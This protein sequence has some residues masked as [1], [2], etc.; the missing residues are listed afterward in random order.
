MSIF[1]DLFLEHSSQ[2]L[3]SHVHQWL[4]LSYQRPR[5][6]L[7]THAGQECG[8][9]KLPGGIELETEIT[10]AESVARVARQGYRSLLLE[11][12]GV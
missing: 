10:A 4:R 7:K 5:F 9:P 3:H 1:H 8:C 12:F 11:A 2:L 6:L